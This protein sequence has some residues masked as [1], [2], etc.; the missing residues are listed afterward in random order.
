MYQTFNLNISDDKQEIKEETIRSAL[1]EVIDPHTGVS[2]VEMGLI[3]EIKIDGAS[4]KIKMTLTT[5][6]CPLAQVLVQQA[7]EKADYW[8][9]AAVRA[10]D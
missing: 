6:F 3:K 4:V 9:S 10:T 8:I 7:K 5:P 2:I 1:N